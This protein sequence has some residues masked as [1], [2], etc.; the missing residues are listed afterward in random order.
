MCQISNIFGMVIWLH[1]QMDNRLITT[2]YENMRIFVSI[3]KILIPD[4]KKNNF[5][6][7]L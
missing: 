2:F 6:F 7:C 1:F 3:A 4:L 5:T